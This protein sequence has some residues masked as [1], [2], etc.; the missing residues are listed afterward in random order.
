ML[1]PVQATGI[2]GFAA[3]F[4][5]LLFSLIHYFKPNYVLAVIQEALRTK[6]YELYELTQF[7]TSK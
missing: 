5:A 6:T 7:F 1:Y 2:Y 4:L 3:M